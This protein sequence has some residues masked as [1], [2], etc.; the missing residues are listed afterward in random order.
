MLTEM[1]FHSTSDGNAEICL[2]V[3]AARATQVMEAIR[4]VL[5][6]AGHKVH[7]V[8]AEGERVFSVAEVFPDDCPA[9]R[10]QGLRGKEDLTQAELATRLGISQNRISDMESG[11]R[12]ISVNMAKKIGKEFGIAYQVFV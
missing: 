2:T 8:N 7:R 12:P 11:K 5:S 3:P 9:H 10:L 6:L 1:K 4:G